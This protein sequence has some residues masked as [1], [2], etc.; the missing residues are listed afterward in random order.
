MGLLTKPNELT[1][2]ETYAGLIYGQPGV[3]K[4]TLA[5]SGVNPV[6]IDVDRG[7]YRVEKRYQVPSLQVESY[8]QVL[9]L[10]NSNELEGFDTIVIDTMGK[11]IDSMGE[12]VAKNNPKYRQSNGQLTMQGWG[13]IKIEFRALVILINSKKKSVI[14]VAHESEEKEGDVT[15]KRPD[16]S[17]SAGKDIVKELD[18]MGY[19]E[20]SGNKRTISF[21]PSS[22]YYAKNSMGLDDVIEIPGIQ[23]GNSFIKDVVV[24]AIKNRREQDKAQAGPYDELIKTIDNIVNAAKDIIAINEAYGKLAALNHI[25]DSKPYAWA[26]ISEAAKAL[27]GAWDKAAK[28]FTGPAMAEAPKEPGQQV[29][30]L[31]NKAAAP[32]PR[33]EASTV[34]KLQL[35]LKNI[36]SSVNGKGNA[37]FTG[38]EYSAV[39]ETVAGLK[40][41]SVEDRVKALLRLL[42]EKKLLMI[43]RLAAI[44]PEPE[45]PEGGYSKT[46]SREDLF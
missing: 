10:I 39:N 31:P 34:E 33:E 23:A 3:G 4:T 41:S 25:W 7:M 45:A 21:A 17:G 37:V 11:L 40:S 26:K 43:N 14:F 28:Q 27:N 32:E 38:D 9:D 22:A 1:M 29:N 44:G 5:L 24:A 30:A 16:V 12:Y 36:M 19:M 2:K 18:F 8:R 46:V 15:K 35:E 20:M 6:C 42:E 13:Q